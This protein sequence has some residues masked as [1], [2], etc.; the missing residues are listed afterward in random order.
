MT[1]A[2]FYCLLSFLACSTTFGQEDIANNNP[3]FEGWYAD[4]EG[5]VFDHT[6]WVYPTLSDDYEKQLQFDALS[7][8]D[9]VNW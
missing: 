5:A 6:Y 1:R 3:I 9:L 4:P 8:K 7:S 2:S